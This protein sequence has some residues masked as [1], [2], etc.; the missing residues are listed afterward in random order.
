MEA[1][2]VRS[3]TVTMPVE[4]SPAARTR[5]NGILAGLLRNPAFLLLVDLALGSIAY[6]GAWL[7]RISIPLPI[8][9]DLLPQERWDA[10]HH[11]W[12]LL[13]LSQAF[14]LY[15]FGLYDEIR[16]LRYREILS[17]VA[18]A[19]VLQVLAITSLFYL[20]NGIF[21]RSVILIFGFLNILL[22]TVWRF[23]VK[24]HLLSG[25]SRVLVVGEN[26]ASALEIAREITRNPWMGLRIVGMVIGS[27]QDAGS[28]EEL[29]A[30]VLGHLQETPAVIAKY[31]I[32]E[33]IFAAQHSWRDEVLHSLSRMESSCAPRIAIHPS[34]Y[35][36]AIGRLRHINI[37]DTPLIEVRRTTNEPLVR[38]LKRTFDLSFS[39]FCLVLLSPLLLLVAAAIK[40]GSPGPVFYLQERVGKGGRI[41]RLL[42]FR[43]M[44][45]DAERFS[46]ETLAEPGDPRVTPIGSILR[47]FRVDEIPQFFNVVKGDM[48]FVGPRPERPGFVKVFLETLPGY[49]ERHRV[50]PGM[51]GLAQV[52]GYYDTAAENK[53]RYDL[54]YI[55]NYTFSLDLLIL[56]ETVKVILTR[57]GS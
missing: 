30:P 56:L 9:Q 35:E 20:S 17:H 18:S 1:H 52:R 44:V 50:K 51:T 12:G 8:T 34:V 4:V 6:G 48:S 57:R 11:F 33:V 29:P 26:L 36:I 24:S 23:Y 32:E 31:G 38:L 19:A 27:D 3:K 22:V 13:V 47:R 28:V 42:K 2:E 39:V 40:V 53:L 55:Y 7:V 25:T 46:G 21:P 16:N 37:Y 5:G 49:N 54:A 45:P 41:F 15:I 43:T 10:V 14:F